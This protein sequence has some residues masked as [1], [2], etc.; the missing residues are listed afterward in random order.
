[1][2]IGSG[3]NERNMLGPVQNHMQF[4]KA[5]HLVA[6]TQNKGHGNEEN[7]GFPFIDNGR[8]TLIMRGILCVGG[9]E[10]RHHHTATTTRLRLSTLG[11]PP[12]PR[13]GAVIVYPRLA[14]YPT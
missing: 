11:I 2:T 5:T 1:M 8:T 9:G 6:D 3:M 7:Y 4:D 10:H 12:V 14:L 13:P